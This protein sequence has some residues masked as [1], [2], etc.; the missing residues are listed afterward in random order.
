[1][2]SSHSRTAS[3]ER[4]SSKK[5]KTKEV[6]HSS[7]HSQQ[8]ISYENE[9]AIDGGAEPKNQ[10]DKEIDE[11]QAKLPPVNKAALVAWRKS[12]IQ[13]IVCTCKLIEVTDTHASECNANDKSITNDPSVDNVNVPKMLT[14][15]NVLPM[16]TDNNRSLAFNDEQQQQQKPQ[17]SKSANVHST[18]M[19]TSTSIPSVATE[20]MNVAPAPVK[21]PAVKSI[22]DL[23]YDDDDPISFKL[24]HNNNINTK[25]SSNRDSNNDISDD[26]SCD[27]II[28]NENI[29]RD[30]DNDDASM[31]FDRSVPINSTANSNYPMD[32]DDQRDQKFLDGIQT[33]VAVAI[34][35][36]E[37]LNAP[38][39]LQAIEFQSP[40]RV[41]EDPDCKAKQ[42]FITSK[43]SI[44]EFH[45]EKLHTSYIPN[46]NGNWDEAMSDEQ[47][48]EAINENPVPMVCDDV[49]PNA[50]HNIESS[51]TMET[52]CMDAKAQDEADA[53][54]ER[55]DLEIEPR[56]TESS[57]GL[58]ER[59]VP[60]CNH[61]TMD[62]LPKNL[63]HINLNFGPSDEVEPDVFIASIT[64]EKDEVIVE[65]EPSPKPTITKKQRIVQINDND[66]SF[67]TRID[68]G[69]RIYGC[70]N[71]ID[72]IDCGR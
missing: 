14:D 40:F 47:K 3:T 57:V 50:Q 19:A 33:T 25:L 68:R 29:K 9:T 26:K 10:I 69:F 34:V 2:L 56:I 5:S 17:I 11:L 49:E 42:F 54:E 16:P 31:M 51:E 24:N 41:E 61:I 39:D 36:D 63:N 43:Q 15:C 71:D 60:L 30:G 35:K 44:T 65:R 53:E 70:G 62:R 28:L 52:E 6:L 32:M 8:P 18:V 21:K 55:K 1:M 4:N 67:G 59:V 27:E 46:I 22:F 45:I 48:P 23:D 66:E 37:P 7:D 12:N 13:T 20:Q 58:Y 38:A 72:E 64:V